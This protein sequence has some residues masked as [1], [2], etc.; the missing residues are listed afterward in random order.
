MPR[1][2]A[3]IPAAGAGT[4]FGGDK[5][6]ADLRGQPVLR[7]TASAFAHHPAIDA[8]VVVAGAGAT[9]QIRDALGGLPKVEAVVPGGASRQ[10][11]VGIGLFALGGEADDWV[12]VHDGARPLVTPDIL[13]R[14]LDG[15]QKNGNAVAAVP[16]SDTL[17]AADDAQTVTRT[18]GRD[19]L[20]AVQTPQCFR[21]QTLFDAHVA[22][23]DSGFGGTDEAGLV[24][25]LEPVHLVLGALDNLKITRPEDLA[26]AETILRGRAP[27]G[28][29][30]IGFGYDI[31]RFAAG[32]RLVLGGVEIPAPQGLDG[33]SDA[34]VLLHAVCDALLGAAGL[35]DIGQ[36]YPNTDPALSGISS[37]RLLAD[38]FARLQSTG[39]GIIN[40][41]A[42]VIAEA[43]K[44]GPFVPLMRDAISRVLHLDPSR[45]GLK[46]TTNEGLGALGAGLGIAAH[47]VASLTEKE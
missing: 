1:V 2:I 46:A 45:I 43:P 29:T 40:V 36:L 9:G 12:L 24:E 25:R 11:S 34:D 19:G 41:D 37:L 15:A 33:H 17:K 26:L 21:L 35:P 38:V 5:L 31:H 44:I 39:L 4:R 14:C 13:D 10:E 42:T 7:R 30:R 28:H 16:V 32:R 18:V 3:L 20:W 6:L 23:R 22:A 27:M 8:I 47:A